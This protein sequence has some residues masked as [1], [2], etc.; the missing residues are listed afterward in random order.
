VTLS[1]IYLKTKYTQENTKTQQS[2][3]SL[4]LH[5]ETG[6]TRGWLPHRAGSPMPVGGGDAAAVPPEW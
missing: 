4:N 3:Q 1:T 6:V 2:H 5:K